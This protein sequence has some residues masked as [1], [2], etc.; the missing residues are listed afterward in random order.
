[1][2]GRSSANRGLAAKRRRCTAPRANLLTCIH[3]LPQAFVVV[4]GLE[5]ALED[6][7]LALQLDQTLDL[8]NP[9]GEVARPNVRF[10]FGPAAR[11]PGLGEPALVARRDPGCSG[12]PQRGGGAMA[13]WK[14]A[15]AAS[16]GPCDWPLQGVVVLGNFG[17]SSTAFW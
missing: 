8:A 10:P 1:V 11:P 17:S 16:T 15:I 6:A 14:Q 4:I 3:G 5:L 9:R 7:E 2:R 13:L 12:P